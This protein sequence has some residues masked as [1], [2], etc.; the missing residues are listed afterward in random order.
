VYVY[1]YAID[2]YSSNPAIGQREAARLTRIKFGLESFAHTTLGRALKAFTIKNEAAIDKNNP[3][4][5]YPDGSETVT[6]HKED[7][8]QG[9]GEN[10]RRCFPSARQTTA[11]RQ[12]AAQIIGSKQGWQERQK[13]IESY[14]K[15]VWEVFRR[16]RR[17][18]L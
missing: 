10:K 2:L 18:L 4:T 7:S 1:L 12:R 9:C 11:Q 16:H 13:G 14:L 5:A 17:L 6:E 15:L 8:S 3:E